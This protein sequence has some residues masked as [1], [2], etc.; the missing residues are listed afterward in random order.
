MLDESG[1]S[2]LEI[3][4]AVEWGRGRLRFFPCFEQNGCDFFKGRPIHLQYCFFLRPI[5]DRV[6]REEHV[7]YPFEESAAILFLPI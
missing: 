6:E 4:N 2:M 3:I 7:I 1:E 5:Y